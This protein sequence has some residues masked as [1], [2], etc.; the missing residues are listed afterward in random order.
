MHNRVLRSE[1]GSLSRAVALG[2][3][4]CGLLFVR[5]APAQEISELVTSDQPIP[6][7][8]KSWSLFL[9]C[10]P[11]WVVPEGE[12]NLESL[13]TRFRAFGQA[14]GPEHLAVCF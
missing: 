2:V 5:A 14:L 3:L 1:A 8:Y 11:A 12:S 4:P 13:Y 9:V 6:E 10:N 7:H